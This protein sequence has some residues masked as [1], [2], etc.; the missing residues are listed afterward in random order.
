[1]H[2]LGRSGARGVARPLLSIVPALAIVADV[3]VP[4][5]ASAGAVAGHAVV[6][7]V[8]D[9]SRVTLPASLHPRARPELDLGRMDPGVRL[10]GMS[11]L[12]RMSAQQKTLEERELSA[13]QD[14]VSPRYRQ[15]FTPERYAAEFGASAS[16]V[17]RTEAWLASQGLSVEGSSRTATRVGFSGTI[18]QIEHAFH[19]EM[20]RYR[21]HGE[22]HFA[23]SGAPSVPSDLAN[24]VLGLHAL[25]D[26][27][28]RPSQRAQPQYA[29]PVTEAD[30]A[31][32]TY[33]SLSPA[34]FAK[35]YDLESLY[36]AHITGAGQSIAVA[37]QS[38]FND[39]DIAAFRTTFGLP[40]NPAV[41]VL[42]PNSGPAVGNDTLDE[43]ELNIEW[44]GAVAPDATILSV[45]TGD[46]PNNDALDA[47]MYAIE[48]RTAPVLSSSFGSCEGWFT[49]ADVVFLGE[50]ADMATL[51]GMT[52]LVAA[53]DTGAAGCDGQSA[54]VAQYGKAVIF[55][56]SLPSFVAVGGTQFQLTANNRPTYLDNELNA[57][58]YIPESAWNET[59]GDIDAGYGGLGAGGG[60]ASRL[61]TKPFWQV[62]YT[63]NDGQ[64]DLPDVALSASADILP[65]AVS[66]SWTAADGDAATPQPQMLTA[67]GGTSVAAPAFAGILALVNQAVAEADAGAP[68]GLGN[69][70]P[71]LYALANNPAST[72]AMH[73]I[74]TGDNLV[75]C[76]PGSPDCPSS[77]PYQFG[78]ASGLGYDESTGLG[79]I[80]VANLVAAWRALTPTSTA[81]RVTA[82]GLAEGSQL[83]LTATVSSSAA[84]N[85][86]TGSVAF[87]FMSPGGASG[88]P[89]GDAGS[90]V[91]GLLGASAVTATTSNG[92]QGATASLTASAP[93]GLN[94]AGTRIFAFYGGDA[95]YLASSS[96]PSSVSGA[97]TLAICPM[98]V[99]LAVGQGG[100]TF[101]TTG[102]HPPIRW[103][104]Y[105]DNT[106]TKESA[107]IVCSNIDGGAFTVGPKVGTVNV[108]ATDQDES[109]VTAEV[110]VVADSAD[111]GL[112]PIPDGSCQPVGE[113]DG[114]YLD[115]MPD[116]A[117]AGAIVD[118]DVDATVGQLQDGSAGVEQAS[119]SKSGC[120][121]STAGGD[122]RCATGGW[123]GSA[124]LALAVA[125]GH[126]S[127]HRRRRLRRLHRRSGWPSSRR[128]HIGSS[129][130]R[131]RGR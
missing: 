31:A 68:L 43:G 124:L 18:A 83:Q 29:L 108:A 26:F 6:A 62:P 51:E 57:L 3:G 19:T 13:L 85:P 113:V 56:A 126:L 92:V 102:G 63:P 22:R 5:V 128:S 95:H 106:C 125:R 30:G 88:A 89:S 90:G 79:S 69:V 94:G 48:Q 55:P 20:H 46:T 107:K 8:G 109:F 7:T 122:G 54:T 53:G 104:L 120:A 80:D 12:L 130:A 93:G 67:Y 25:H 60:G 58:S 10:S 123:S 50:Y 78:F 9:P 99:T 61:V 47:L 101:T 45:F 34:D 44:T 38:D 87:Y 64:R 111:G 110:T 98:A 105:D 127:R 24:L 70:N 115:A 32:G 65:Y 52:V 14:P 37:E 86:V 41:H 84:T 17:A 71:I 35:I 2:R 76:A 59:L 103:N 16:D 23:M 97:S 21:V 112:P 49:P 4:W 27:R 1:M 116:V 100:V 11:L 119:T 39:A 96:T 40:S 36:A 81:L 72:R 42:V 114:S 91:S 117:A 131:T 118:A 74:T 15:W 28:V 33:P 77:A 129:S 121:C 73:D 66:M 82:S 75:P